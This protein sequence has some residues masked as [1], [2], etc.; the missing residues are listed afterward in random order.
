MCLVVAYW[1][2]YSI[3]FLF[4]TLTLGRNAPI[5]EFLVSIEQPTLRKIKHPWSIVYDFLLLCQYFHHLELDKRYTQSTPASW[6]WP[7]TTHIPYQ[8]CDSCGGDICNTWDRMPDTGKRHDQCCAQSLCLRYW[9]KGGHV[10]QF[11]LR[12]L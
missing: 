3:P 4:L 10:T 5:Q 6:N 2:L 9:S 1:Y 11:G 8:T 7:I 12:A